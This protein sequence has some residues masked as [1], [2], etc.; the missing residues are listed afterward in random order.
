MRKYTL[1]DGARE[2]ANSRLA[3]RHDPLTSPGWPPGAARA[4]SC[5]GTSS[6]AF[7]AMRPRLKTVCSLF[8]LGVYPVRYFGNIHRLGEQNTGVRGG[9]DGKNNQLF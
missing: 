2:C 4:T 1:V 5:S 7:T 9:R 6:D 3:Y 8:I